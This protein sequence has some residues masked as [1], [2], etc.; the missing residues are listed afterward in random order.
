MII[1]QAYL[2]PHVRVSRDEAE[3]EDNDYQDKDDDEPKKP[4]ATSKCAT[5]QRL[6]FEFGAKTNMPA[7]LHWLTGP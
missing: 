7:N 5:R 4:L 2:N 6:G 1:K 3:K